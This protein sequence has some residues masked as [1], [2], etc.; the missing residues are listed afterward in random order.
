MAKSK[1]SNLKI[2]LDDNFSAIIRPTEK[3]KYVLES[4]G[5]M[6]YKYIHSSSLKK[7]RGLN[8]ETKSATTQN[9]FLPKF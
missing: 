1:N 9:L 6:W 5:A 7:I 3:V 2:H 4:V 8:I